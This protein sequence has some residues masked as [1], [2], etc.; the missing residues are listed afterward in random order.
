M[1]AI[2]KQHAGIP[3]EV[4]KAI[5]SSSVPEPAPRGNFRALPGAAGALFENQLT[6]LG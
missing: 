4:F 6:S 3:M 5:P 2:R 1:N